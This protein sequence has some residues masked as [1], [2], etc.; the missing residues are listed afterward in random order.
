VR[1][2]EDGSVV[3]YLG[4]ANPDVFFAGMT[5]EQAKEL[6]S[7]LERVAKD[8]LEAKGRKSKS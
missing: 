6:A 3:M 1:V 8:A 7:D 5:I 2:W 4:T